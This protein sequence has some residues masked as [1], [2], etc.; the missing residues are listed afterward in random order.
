[1]YLCDEMRLV[2]ISATRLFAECLAQGLEAQ[3][4]VNAV[5]VVADAAEAVPVLQSDRVAAVLID[6]SSPGG[7]EEA[8]QLQSVKSDF[9]ILGLAVQDS[10]GDV[11]RCARLGCGGIIPAD[12]PLSEVVRIV[13]RAL[14]GEAVCT[15]AAVAGLM[16]AVATASTPAE[17]IPLSSLTPREREICAMVCEGMTNKEI[18]QR[19]HCS[20]GTVKN[21]VHN[22]LAKLDLPRRSAL[23]AHID[24]GARL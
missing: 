19:A 16:R 23:G 8:R 13:R 15:P 11:I 14:R 17:R 1:M 7:W 18:A 9:C 10:V 3:D 12:T 22:I 5:G 6:L 21:H 20:E 24:H 4:G 2:I